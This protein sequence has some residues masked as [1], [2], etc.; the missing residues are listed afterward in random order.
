MTKNE[1]LKQW[2]DA[3]KSSGLCV[4]CGRPLDRE[5]RYCTKCREKLNQKERE[6]RKWYL[7]H[8]ICPRC[9]KNDL[10]GDETICPECRAKEVNNAMKNRDMDRY[11]SYHNEWAKSTY[12]K[13]KEAGICTR[14]GKRKASDGYTTC[15][16]C[17]AKDNETR[18]IRVGTSDRAE[19]ISKGICYFCENPVKKGYKV[20]E[21]HYQMNVE[22]AEKGRQSK[23]AQE[24]I[25][26]IKKIQ[27]GGAKFGRCKMD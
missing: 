15:A 1:Y 6:L 7:S 18:R 25:K 21:K 2:R 26:D 24:Y 13:R 19:R 11:N 9:R 12:K 23:A 14:C 5:G 8:R 17:R 4:G 10:M 22:K 16:I 20:C 27:Y 3:R